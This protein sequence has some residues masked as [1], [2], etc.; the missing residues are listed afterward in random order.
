[1]A[2]SRYGTKWSHDETV[3][4]LGLY[5]QIPF[6]KINQTSPEVVRIARLM[7][8]EPASL[9]MKMGNIG[10]LDSTLARR[11]VTGLV[12]GAKMEE[13]VWN[14]YAGRR[15]ELATRYHELILGLNRDRGVVAALDD[16]VTIKT[17]QGLDGVRLA[18][19]RINQS[20]FRR[21]V[22]SAYDNKCCI[23]GL[24]GAKLL[25][26]SHIK[27]WALCADGNERTDTANGLCLNS[28]HDR[29]FDKGLIT[30]DEELKVVLSASLKDATP[31]D[32]FADYFV[33]YEGQMITLPERGRP[34]EAFLSY[35]R[36]NVFKG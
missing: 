14:E 35:H 34:S 20:F 9:S 3:I 23:T 15:D 32:V 17:P 18:H 5:F 2:E 8:R 10:R 7:G 27:P 16:D 13:Q 29:A 21:S 24:T 12:N 22:L 33:R 30:L 26:A 11:G 36:T 25:I 4:A 6:G 1:M 19:Y 28:L 31:R